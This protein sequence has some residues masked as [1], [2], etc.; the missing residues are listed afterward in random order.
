VIVRRRRYGV[1]APGFPVALEA[2]RGR[3][4]RLC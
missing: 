1:K 3:R 2:A 4:R